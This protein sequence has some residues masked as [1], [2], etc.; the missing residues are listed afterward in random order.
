MIGCMS[1]YLCKEKQAQYHDESVG[2]HS[3]AMYNTT[4]RYRGALHLMFN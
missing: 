3:D 2:I 1:H 4:V